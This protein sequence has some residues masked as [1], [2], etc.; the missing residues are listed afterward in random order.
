MYISRKMDQKIGFARGELLTDGEREHCSK[1]LYDFTCRMPW[2][3]LVL[4]IWS[5]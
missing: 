1:I 5:I 2:H 3:I 4:N